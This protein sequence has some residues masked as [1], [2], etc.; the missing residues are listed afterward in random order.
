M[1]KALYLFETTLN[2]LEN[3]I[4]NLPDE[5]V[6]LVENDYSGAVYAVQNAVNKLMILDNIHKFEKITK[7]QMQ[8]LFSSYDSGNGINKIVTDI[9]YIV[10]TYDTI[11]TIEQKFNVPWLKIQD[12]N[13]ILPSEVVTGLAIRIPIETPVDQNTIRDIPTIGDQQGNNILGVDFTNDLKEGED[14]DFKTLTPEE[15]FKQSVDNRLTLMPGSVPYYEEIG[16]DPKIPEGYN[17]EEIESIL[18]LRIINALS[19]DKRIK[20][21]SISD[22]TKN[23]TSRQFST[24]IQ[25]ISGQQI[26]LPI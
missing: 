3:K 8:Y 13:N 9:E 7:S 17:N 23:K 22:Q 19:D 12:Y 25:T 14:G 26:E 1:E 2:T 5:D 20:N 15:S 4:L 18:Q 11:R 24:N 6:D 10:A 21:I 16:F